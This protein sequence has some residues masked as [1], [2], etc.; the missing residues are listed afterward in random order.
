MSGAGDEVLTLHPARLRWAATGL[1][2]VAVTVG[3]IA[4]L[5]P[6]GGTLSLVGMALAV[7]VFGSGS[8]ASIWQLVPGWS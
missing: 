3:A 6:D 5:D 1:G 7:I 2:C 8:V 4:L